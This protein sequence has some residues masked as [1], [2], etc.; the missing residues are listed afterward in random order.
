MNAVHHSS[1]RELSI[2]S[3]VVDSFVKSVATVF[4]VGFLVWGAVFRR[5]CM[6]DFRETW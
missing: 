4:V 3:I 1:R 2:K 5:G 6:Y